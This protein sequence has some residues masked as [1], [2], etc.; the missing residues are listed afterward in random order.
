MNYANGLLWVF[1]GKGK[2]GKVFE[3]FWTYDIE[4]NVWGKVRSEGSSPSRRYGHG[5]FIYDAHWEEHEK[6]ILKKKSSN[7][8][9]LSAPKPYLTSQDTLISGDSQNLRMI[10]SF[11]FDNKM[12][13]LKTYLFFGQYRSDVWEFNFETLKWKKLNYEGTPKSKYG[14]AT[15][16]IGNGCAFQF[17]GQHLGKYSKN[18]YIIDMYNKKW[19]KV[20]RNKLLNNSWPHARRSHVLINTND[21]LIVHG[22]GSNMRG[23]FESVCVLP[24][25]SLFHV[26]RVGYHQG[27][28][29]ST[30][31][32]FN[33]LK[34]IHID[35]ITA[36]SI[37]LKTHPNDHEA[38][39]RRAK[40]YLESRVYQKAF[41]DIEKAIELDKTEEKMIIKAKILIAL[42]QPQQAKEILESIQKTNDNIDE[43]NLGLMTIY[44][45]T[46]R[47]DLATK[48]AKDLLQ[49]YEICDN[50]EQAILKME[51]LKQYIYVLTETNQFNE[52]EPRLM[53][54]RGLMR[55]FKMSNRDQTMKKITSRVDD[56]KE[57]YNQCKKYFEEAK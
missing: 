36:E 33:N 43:I 19:V 22:G 21:D 27:G 20:Q 17:G 51:I 46:H 6:D 9:I 2:N 28:H 25:T 34:P 54:L 44:R 13:I 23:Y 30:D 11:G 24:L 47:Y 15:I 48:Y 56:H 40:A 37:Y 14:H 31:E 38:Y 29:Q 57:L 18:A 45:C 55:S 42:N 41:D 5:S 53:S 35:K 26:Y 49:K 10:V 3:D 8:N 32:V 1:G 12:G 16:P 39:K 4:D 7:L 50:E 52:C